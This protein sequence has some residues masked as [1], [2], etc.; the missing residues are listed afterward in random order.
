M[1]VFS[2]IPNSMQKLD[3][4]ND[5]AIRADGSIWFTDPSYGLR[6]RPAEVPGRW[7]FRLD[8]ESKTLRVVYK[9]FDTLFITARTSLS[10][11]NTLATGSKPIGAKW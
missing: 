1:L 7:V 9:G 11:V 4:P 6:G 10:M 5:L 8:P 3:S 2:D